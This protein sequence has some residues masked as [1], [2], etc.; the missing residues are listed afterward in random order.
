MAPNPSRC[1]ACPVDEFDGSICPDITVSICCSI[2][3]RRR[4][5]V[6]WT[7]CRLDGSSILS[8]TEILR[9][10]LLERRTSIPWTGLYLRLPILDTA[11]KSIDSLHPRI[12]LVAGPGRMVVVNVPPLSRP[13]TFLVT[14]QEPPR[15]LGMRSDVA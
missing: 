12:E 10:A 15:T 4:L 14:S 9:W 11:W 6:S 7:N 13:G 3:A 8:D 2:G 1:A 5:P